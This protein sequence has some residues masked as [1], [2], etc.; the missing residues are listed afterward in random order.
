MDVIREKRET[1]RK[2]AGVCSVRQD[3]LPN[4]PTANANSNS[5]KDA[6][7]HDVCQN[8]SRSTKETEEL[9]NEACYLLTVYRS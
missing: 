4:Y 6:T 5:S 9:Q 2:C 7:P 3:G 1:S 8:V